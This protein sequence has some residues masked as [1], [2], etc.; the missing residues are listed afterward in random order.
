MDFPFKAVA[1]WRRLFSTSAGAQTV[2]AT[3]PAVREARMWVGMLSERWS[4]ERRWDLVAVY[5]GRAS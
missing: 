4:W 3:V 1:L 5:L 2:V